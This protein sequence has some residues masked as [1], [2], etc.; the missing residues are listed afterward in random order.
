MLLSAASVEDAS[1]EL[2]L[3]DSQSGASLNGFTSIQRFR[4]GSE[5][6]RTAV[7]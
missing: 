3:D 1:D 5:L 7:L 2:A 6:L 4:H